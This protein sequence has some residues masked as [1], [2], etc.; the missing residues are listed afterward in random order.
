VDYVGRA[1]LVWTRRMDGSSW[2]HGCVVSLRG[3]GRPSAE[4]A[5]S[6]GPLSRVSYTPARCLCVLGE[7][8]RKAGRVASQP[9]DHTPTCGCSDTLSTRDRRSSRFQFERR[10]VIPG[11]ARV[12][13]VTRQEHRRESPC[14]NEAATS[15][16]GQQ[17]RYAIAL[18]DPRPDPAGPRM[19]LA[20]HGG[21]G[22]CR[23]SA[24]DSCATNL[25]NIAS[26]PTTL[27]E[28]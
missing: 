22:R 15:A 11:W 19:D 24:A 4:L 28:P 20:G 6:R 8:V 26:V 5:L 3:C 7:R 10:G 25:Q 2:I 13:R 9:S 12:L 16:A 17:V 21:R 23:M 27:A 1:R 18:P 14:F